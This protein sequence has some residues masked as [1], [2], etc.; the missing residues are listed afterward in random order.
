MNVSISPKEFG[1]IPVTIKIYDH[2]LGEGIIEVEKF[3][4]GLYASV[5]DIIKGEESDVYVEIHLNETIN[6]TVKV[7]FNNQ[8][9]SY[10]LVNGFGILVLP[11]P[12]DLPCGSYS[13]KVF[14]EGNDYFNSSSYETSFEI[15][16]KTT[17][18]NVF[19]FTTLQNH[20]NH[21][22]AIFMLR[23]DYFYSSINDKKY[24]N[25]VLISQD[26]YVVDG[27]GHTIYGNSTARIFDVKG[28]NV[29]IKNLH[30]VNFNSSEGAAIYFHESSSISN[31]NFMSGLGE[32]GGALYFGGEGTV[33]NSTFNLCSGEDGGAVYFA[34]VGSVINSTFVNC[35]AKYGGAVYMSNGGDVEGSSFI[36]NSASA[37][38][39]SI[40]GGGIILS[41]NHSN[42]T[43]NYGERGSAIY[44]F[45]RGEF[46]NSIFLNNKARSDILEINYVNSL[47]SVQFY[48]FNSY[49]HAILGGRNMQFSNVTYWNGSIVNSDDIAPEYF[50]LEGIDIY[51]EIYNWTTKELIESVSL[52]TDKEGQVYYDLSHYDDW[53]YEI[54]AYHYDDLYY[55]YIDDSEMVY[56]TRNSSS[57]HIDINDNEEF[58]YP[59][60][61][62]SINFAVVNATEV[63]IVLTYIDGSVIL[64]TITDESNVSIDNL[65]IDCSF[66][67]T[68]Y[69][70]GNEYFAPSHDSKLF[71]ILK[72]IST[73]HISPIEDILY[74]EKD[75][76]LEITGER[77]DIVTI[78]VVDDDGNIVSDFIWNMS[79]DR[80][81]R[82]ILPGHYTVIATNYGNESVSPSS[83][84][85]SFTIKKRPNDAWITVADVTYPDN[86]TIN[87][88]A[89]ID[90]VYYLDI[91]GTK[92][93]LNVINRRGSISL[94]LDAGIYDLVIN[95]SDPIYDFSYNPTSFVVNK[96]HNSANVSVD[97]DRYVGKVIAYVD[98]E[99]DGIYAIDIN[100][101]I[102]HIKVVDGKGSKIIYLDPGFYYAN[103][104][105]DDS[106][107]DTII[108]NAEFELKNRINNVIVTVENVTYP[109]SVSI[110]INADIDGEYILDI[111]GTNHIVIVEDGI[112]N[113][114]EFLGV[115][116][117]YANVTFNDPYILSNITNAEFE[118]LKGTRNVTVIVDDV[119]Y[120]EEVI[121]FL[122]SNVDQMYLVNVNGINKIVHVIDG[123]GNLSLCLDI[124]R[125]FVDVVLHN[126]NYENHVKNASFEVLKQDTV[127]S[128]SNKAYVINYG[129]GYEIVLK[130]ALGNV[131]SGKNVTFTL[132]GMDIGSIVTDNKG[133]A[134]INLSAIVLKTVKLGT[135]NL[136]IA[137][138]GDGN[139]NSISKTVKIVIN[140]ENASIV[141]KNKAYVINYG[142][143]Y[144]I[145]LKDSKGKALANRK[146]TFT[147]RGK[148]IGSATTNAKGVATIKLSVK[149]L[150]AAKA[151]KRKLVIKFSGDKNYSLVSKTVK[152]TIKKEKTKIAA[153]KKAFKRTKKVKKYSIKL[154]NS[155]GKAVKKVK[156]TLRVKG[157]T[158]KAKTNNK[159][160]AVFKIKNLR[161]RGKYLAKIKFKGNKYYKAIT[162]KVKISV[163]G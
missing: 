18:D 83:T 128:A 107:Y 44:V 35:S 94:S 96:A 90:G 31:C 157:K 105:F 137:F 21:N 123:K 57:V 100:G 101:T 75:I 65:P 9:L 131:L 110:I 111:N 114:S 66:N 92:E 98:A 63:R 95:Y 7:E 112:G 74:D 133:I 147:L 2:Y 154:K 145:A 50:L 29:T 121:I 141:A 13:V 10:N 151:G 117:Y 45:S 32:N 138:A 52:V 41:V 149:M 6:E 20:I 153:K 73:I 104:T 106:N 103:L 148:Y 16:E 88:Q 55:D 87:I 60:I 93:T 38:G 108:K 132:D 42:F 59:N 84:S 12:L 125:Y 4:P 70:L 80:L 156:L 113:A 36:N 163:K 126:P 30:F 86:V 122:E 5:D 33:I 159:G 53:L 71:K 17:P 8:N 19:E 97:A 23:D 54:R 82:H 161:K 68:V 102:K 72:A 26:N 76:V 24:K 11:L 160:R 43:G 130:D 49:I 3:N 34:D 14:Y 116:H 79:Y 142:G 134:K 56:F 28:A 144:Q 77:L 78:K 47:I 120:G 61:P 89:D 162:K 91:N 127:I 158:Y 118:V 81:P 58:Y 140:K 37:M 22:S 150:K 136:V 48:G 15:L 69:N 46:K 119:K 62:E 139:Y 40:Y 51:L 64:D 152:V 129:G 155:K 99:I 109:S 1:P 25:G 143:K 124:G 39:G 27:Q 135:K 67:L 85:T 146:V 115:G